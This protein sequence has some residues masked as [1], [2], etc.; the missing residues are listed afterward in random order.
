M[1]DALRSGAREAGW[2]GSQADAGCGNVAILPI[3][4]FGPVTAAERFG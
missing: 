1:R 2:T 3:E 4:P